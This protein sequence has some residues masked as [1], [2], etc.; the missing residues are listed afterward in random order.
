MA[1]G[2]GCPRIHK[3]KL[4]YT[5]VVRTVHI[6]KA[7]LRIRIVVQLERHALYLEHVLVGLAGGLNSS[8][9]LK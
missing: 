8:L 9:K 1:A 7:K 2:L 3:H 5:H 4:A 6:V